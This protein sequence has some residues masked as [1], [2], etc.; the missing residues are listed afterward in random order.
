MYRS[1]LVVLLAA[2]SGDDEGKDSGA[3][4]A[5]DTDTGTPPTY[6][7]TWEGVQQLFAENCNSC[8]PSQNQIDLVL[9]VE[10]DLAGGQFYVIPGNAADSYLWQVVSGGTITPMPPT[11]LLD[12]AVVEPIRGW[13]DAGAS[14]E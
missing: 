12:P 5:G 13:I 9:L 11:G 1:I 7:A 3:D 10:E 2:C 8:H 14:L 6:P 4:T